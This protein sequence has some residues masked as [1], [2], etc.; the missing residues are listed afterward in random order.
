MNGI[1]PIKMNTKINEGPKKIFISM[2]MVI[3]I[4]VII[5]DMFLVREVTYCFSPQYGQVI[6]VSNVKDFLKVCFQLHLDLQFWQVGIC[7][8]PFSINSLII[9]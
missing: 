8:T 1:E 9:F 4:I 3:I 2:T 7:R 5:V 6:A